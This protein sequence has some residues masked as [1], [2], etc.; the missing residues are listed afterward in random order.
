MIDR[1]AHGFLLRWPLGAAHAF[2]RGG[3]LSEPVGAVEPRAWQGVAK[4]DSLPACGGGMGRGNDACD[5][6]PPERSRSRSTRGTGSAR[7]PLRER[8]I[9]VEHG[10]QQ[11]L[12]AGRALLFRAELG[13]VMAHAVAARH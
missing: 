13:L 4:R 3:T 9:V 1:E 10:L 11:H 2:N 12:G 6:P 5:E 8:A 7:M